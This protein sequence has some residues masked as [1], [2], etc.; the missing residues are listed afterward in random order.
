[1]IYGYCRVSSDEQAA[2]GI[3]IDAQREILH[4]YAAMCQ[5][6]I[7]IFE[8][9]GFSGKNTNRPALR[10]LLSSITSGSVTSV[11][12]WKLDRLSRSLRDTLT[13]IEDVFAPA[14]ATLVSVTESIDTST[15]SGRMML[16]LLAS[17]AQLE[18]EQDSDR[19]VMSHKHL[20]HDCKY[21]GGH[22]PF[23]YTIDDT[24]HYQIDPVTGPVARKV[25]E[26]YLS[27][28]G[29]HSM[30]LHM[31]DPAVL[32][33]L[34]RDKPF[35]K[36]HLKIMLKNEIYAGTYVRRMGDDPRHRIT[37]PETI[38]VPGGVP[39]ML[40][41]DEW[42]R[43]CEIR[44][45]NETISASYRS[46][47]VYPL[48]GLVYC[49]VCGKNMKIRHGGKT[50]A[51]EVERYYTCPSRCVKSARMEHVLSAVAQSLIYM[52]SDDDL[53][54]RACAIVND[55]IA[56]DEAEDNASNIPIQNRLLEIRRQASRILSLIKSTDTPPA[57]AYDDLHALDREEKELKAKL[58]TSTRTYSRYDPAQLAKR[59]R[60]AADIEKLPPEEQ[61]ARIQAAVSKVVVS[62]ES[63]KVRFVCPTW[64][65]DEP[66][67]HVEHT[68]KRIITR[69][70]ACLS[71]SV[72]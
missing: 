36:G 10:R 67:H 43:V 68:I 34:H 19:V 9:A 59:I 8:D 63:Y 14:G 27:H 42:Q 30:L 39:A 5:D 33:Y 15:P 60:E 69:I 49:A 48:A 55:Y 54:N 70:R 57:S 47:T 13:M 25:F 58:N 66:R 45:Q 28:S 31:N 29:Y 50:R 23:G 11:V 44:T 3:S 38:R 40:T 41:A 53:I 16:N 72:S 26:L 1:M 35:D 52:A 71:R 7:E 18:R 20:A 24:K 37:S 21:L 32:A 61:K 56:Q 46:K 22:I 62:D 17:F 4:G 6:K 12:V 2:H 65:G 64:C 51:G